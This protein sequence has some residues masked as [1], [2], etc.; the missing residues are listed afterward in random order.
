ME[1]VKFNINHNVKVKVT[2]YGYETWMQH[3]NKYVHFSGTIKPV[4]LEE[5]KAKA[6]ND[7]Y[8]K[9]QMWDMMSIFGSKMKMG[10]ENPINPNIILLPEKY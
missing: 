1:Q 8:T 10:F 2:D 9:F 7:G 5:L 6:D 4:T 3:E